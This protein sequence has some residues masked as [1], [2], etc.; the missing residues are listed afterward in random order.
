MAS[1]GQKII[2]A[3][4]AQE[5]AARE[6]RLALEADER[7]KRIADFEIQTTKKIEKK[8][9]MK[10]FDELA[11]QIGGDLT[12]RRRQLAELYNAELNMWRE[13]VMTKVETVEERKA[14]IMERAYKLRDARESSRREYIEECYNRQWRDACDDA[15]TL[16]SQAMSQWV[17][18]E[19]KRHIELNQTNRRL[20]AEEEERWVQSWKQQLA[21]LDAKE[22]G[23]GNY[24]L[25]M[26]KDTEAAV[27]EQMKT[28]YELKNSLREMKRKEDE[29]EIAEI[30]AAIAEEDAKQA[31]RKNDAFEQGQ[32]TMKYN[33]ANSGTANEKLRIEKEQDAILLAYAL[34]KENEAK[35]AEQAKKDA[36]RDAALNYRKYLE[37]QMI[38][39]AEDN[40]ATDALRDQEA[41]KVWKAREDA[42]QAR[43]DARNALMKS[44]KESR[45]QQLAMKAALEAKEKEDERIYAAGFIEDAKLGIKR[46]QEEA[47][48]RTKGNREN[49]I[50]L[51]K[52]IQLREAIR[53]KEKQDE[54]LANKT[55]ERMERLHKEK[56]NSQAGNLRLQFGKKANKLFS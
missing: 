42:L 48:H 27:K 11:S 41:M 55:M 8:M 33:E 36:A 7:V 45:E 31:K 29:A 39:D 21:E 51:M 5:A 52:Q 22:D 12:D 19:R 10:R 44:V 37:Q 20:N 3:K 50:E 38:K 6:M 54:Y 15:R 17:G 26:E 28:N 35:A 24:K 47:L 25:Q 30:R 32:L 23:K 18:D 40:S 13:E 14:R 34:R 43:E 4:K 53:E 46:E 49:S 1:Q 56:L 16:D 9:A 2:E